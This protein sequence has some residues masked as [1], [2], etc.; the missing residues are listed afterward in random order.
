MIKSRDSNIIDLTNELY[1][2]E[3]D[4]KKELY[5]VEFNNNKKLQ[6]IEQLKN[7]LLINENMVKS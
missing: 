4:L 5:Q 7:S 3:R 2:V 1:Q 6:E